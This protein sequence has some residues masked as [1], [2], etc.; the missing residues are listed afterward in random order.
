MS[1]KVKL[2]EVALEAGK[3]TKD[4]L[5]GCIALGFSVRSVQ[6][7]VTV[8]EAEQLM[9]YLMNASSQSGGEG[10]VAPAQTPSAAPKHAPT[11]TQSAEAPEPA[12]QAVA[13]HEKPQAPSGGKTP[14]AKQ[15]QTTQPRARD[16]KAPIAAHATTNAATVDKPKQAEK[17]LDKARLPDGFRRPGGG[18]VKTGSTR[19][20][21]VTSTSSGSSP[22]SSYA[23][24]ASAIG[25]GRNRVAADTAAEERRPRKEKKGIPTNKKDQGNRIEILNDRTLDSHDA[26]EDEMIVMPDLSIGISD[27]LAEQERKDQNARKD[28][29]R[30]KT[31]NGATSRMVGGDGIARVKRRRSSNRRETHINET[32]VRV[33]V[34][35]IPEDVRVY[36]FA[37]KVAR[38]IAA[39]IKKLFELGMMVTKNDFLGKDA[40]EILAEEFG[41]E[42][43]T[44]DT[45]SDLDYVAEYDE[46]HPIA[47]AKSS[48][49]PIV[50]I[51]GHVDH[52][53]TSLLD[54]IR[55][56]RVASGEAGGI[57]QHIGAYTVTKNGKEITFIDTPGHEAFSQMRARGANTTDIVII[58]VAADDGVMPQTKEAISH[59]KAAKCPMIVAIN[60]I[61]KPAANLDKVKGEL[62]EAGLT[63]LDWGG[64]TECVGVSAKS[65]VG[66]ESLLETILLQ[67]ELMELRAET[68]VLAKAVVI[69]SSLEKGRGAVATVIVQNG[70]LNVGDN[71][72]AGVS[73]GRIRAIV[74][75]HGAQITSL[76]PSQAG[77]IVGLD[78]VPSSGDVMV[79]MTSADDAKLYA[80]KRSE[81]E[82]QR[83]LSRTT[84][85]TLEDLGS[86]IAEGKLKRL[87]I[88]LKADVQGTLEAIASSLS[89]LRNAE[90]K[91]EIIHS[92]VGEISASDVML[93]AASEHSVILG[94][95]IK[96][97]QII[98][99]RAKAMGV[100]I[101]SYDVIYDLLDD[102]SHLLSGMLSKITEEQ[103]SG[104]AEVR[105]I[106]D[107]PK[108][109]RIAGCMVV[110][111]EITRGAI[112]R[113]VRGEEEIYK[114]RI[115]TLKRFKDDAKEVK[116][117][118]E[119]GIAL[120]GF[121]GIEPGDTI[122]CFKAI[123]VAAIFKANA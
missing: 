51:M 88:I 14:S 81:Y 101:S 73:S 13:A 98:K 75:A 30:A 23:E 54:F 77:L 59:A 123:E 102:V 1:D 17:P 46:A 107:I 62:A 9:S 122:E 67:A 28:F 116:K 99:D 114:G 20:P 106:F 19:K 112:A 92:A 37:E 119:C 71:V 70:T 60:K 66:V 91:A 84:K 74:D 49:P 21:A 110:D 109:G 111:G 26:Y 31:L 76:A 5:N 79:A 39:V 43:K 8:A 7:S 15:P 53:K 11:D 57:T 115:E 33:S 104:K 52:G 72:V 95:H 47:S 4:A 86:L 48:R 27:F 93:A 105:Q 29:D 64:D 12:A 82:R 97:S 121:N 50:T 65:G 55:S 69:E 44:K 120:A 96:P 10:V 22:R 118:L 6:G 117:G 42:V 89:K 18:L 38:P 90:V 85:A 94:F 58:V 108:Q 32:S 35:E 25:Y 36:E 34:I 24:Y 45:G 40:I 2:T 83:V 63:P 68:D 80:Q 61:D 100:R 41:V 113:I 78:L 87:P 16:A 3:T 56:S 103:L